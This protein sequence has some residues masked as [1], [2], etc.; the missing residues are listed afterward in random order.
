MN[1]EVV[2]YKSLGRYR[3]N[4][5]EEWE[6]WNTSY[7]VP[8]DVKASARTQIISDMCYRA[9]CNDDTNAVQGVLQEIWEGI[10]YAHRN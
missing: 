8:Y 3:I 4:T 5:V 10:D 7:K 6:M 1:K 2:V 9:I